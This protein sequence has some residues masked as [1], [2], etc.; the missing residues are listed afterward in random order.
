MPRNYV[1][2][3]SD[4]WNGTSQANKN[5]IQGCAEIA[6]YAGTWRAKEY[7]GFTLAGLRAGGMTVE[8]AGAKLKG[9][10]EEIG[11]VMMADWLKDAGKEGQDLVDAF[12]KMN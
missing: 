9:E 1:I 8:P 11:K 4:V 5:V 3:N 10:F 12:R 6:E 2:I 7:T